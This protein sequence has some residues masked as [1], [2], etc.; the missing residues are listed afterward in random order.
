MSKQPMGRKGKNVNPTGHAHHEQ[1]SKTIF[2]PFK[3]LVGNPNAGQIQKIPALHLFL[4][5]CCQQLPCDNDAECLL[6]VVHCSL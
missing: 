1:T 2:H 6:C 5:W 3:Q 4:Q